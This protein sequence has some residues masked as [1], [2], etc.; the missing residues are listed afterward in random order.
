LLYFDNLKKPQPELGYAAHAWH[1]V[2][3]DML[4]QLQVLMLLLFGQL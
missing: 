4:L 1:A 2:L 3:A